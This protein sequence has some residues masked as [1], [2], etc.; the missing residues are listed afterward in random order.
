M[1]KSNKLMIWAAGIVIG[2]IILLAT[3]IRVVGV[4]QIG[5]ITTFGKISGTNN[6]GLMVK[7]PWQGLTIMNIKTQK[8]Q[9]EASTAS[10]DLQTVVATIALNYHLTPDTAKK[11]F[12]E[13]GSEYVG[14]IVSPILQE[15]IKSITSQY[16]AEDLII[17]RSEVEGKL[18]LRLEEK[19]IPKGITVDNVAL[20]NFDFSKAF[21]DSIEAKQ[22][23]Q[24]NAIKAEYE[25]KT[26]ELH[27]QAQEIQAKTL[28]PAYLE[29][30]AIEK[31]NG[32]MPT[33]VAGGGAIYNIPLVK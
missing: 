8:E 29:L 3:T 33:T 5:I 1:E 16:N 31:W 2:I 26:A 15:S 32:V 22:V 30:Q 21:N 27:S 20:V 13:V 11:M 24:Q 6:S 10:K 9:Q 23:A 17:N 25:L 14:I 12:A 7:A 28:T 19:L 18:R 4:G